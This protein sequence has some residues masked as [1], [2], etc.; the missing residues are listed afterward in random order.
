MKVGD[1]VKFKEGCGWKSVGLVI[2]VCQ[3]DMF[4]VLWARPTDPPDA[5]GWYP[6]IHLE[7]VNENR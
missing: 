1:L 2:A 7:V 5:I 3:I 4:Q 6:L